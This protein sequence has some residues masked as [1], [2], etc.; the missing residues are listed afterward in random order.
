MPALR[1]F[2]INCRRTKFSYQ[3]SQIYHNLVDWVEKFLEPRR[4]LAQQIRL[5]VYFK[6][7][8]EGFH[9]KTNE[10]LNAFPVAEL[11]LR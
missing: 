2:S 4:G 3:F 11:A 9:P 7:K 8:P 5:L 6:K 10:A 1:S